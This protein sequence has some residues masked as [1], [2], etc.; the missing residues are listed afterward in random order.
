MVYITSLNHQ[1][2]I[3]IIFIG[4]A[5]TSSACGLDHI[6]KALSKLHFFNFFP[7]SQSR[8]SSAPRQA[9]PPL[10]AP[11]LELLKINIPRNPPHALI[12]YLMKIDHKQE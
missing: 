12:F 11:L 7:A 1:S 2:L 8:S 6:L 5:L 3:F 9:Q 4:A 10:P